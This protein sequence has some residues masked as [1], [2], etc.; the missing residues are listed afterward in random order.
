M[1]R[2]R[3]HVFAATRKALIFREFSAPEYDEARLAAGYRRSEV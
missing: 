3:E 2:Q 1:L